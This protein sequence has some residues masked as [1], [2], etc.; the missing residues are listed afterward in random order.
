[1]NRREAQ[2]FRRWPDVRQAEYLAPEGYRAVYQTN[3]YTPPRRAWQCAADALAGDYRTSM[4]TCPTT[5][6]SSAACCMWRWMFQGRPVHA[7]V[8]HLG[9]IP[10]SRVRQIQ[11]LQRFIEREVPPGAPLVVAGTSTTG[12]ANSNAC[13]PVMGCTSLKAEAPAP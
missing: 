4:R 13:W 5:A 7:I 10:G 9:L 2:Y 6:S 8:V 11:Q 3:A 12:A 1:M